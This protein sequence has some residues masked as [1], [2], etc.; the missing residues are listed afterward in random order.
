MGGNALLSVYVE[1]ACVHMWSINKRTRTMSRYLIFSLLSF[2][3]CF[4]LKEQRV[5]WEQ[6]RRHG[7]AFLTPS[8]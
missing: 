4:G 6:M 3:F 2:K 5:V 1:N 8:C 7:P